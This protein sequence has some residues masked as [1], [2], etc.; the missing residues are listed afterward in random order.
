MKKDEE[1]S[2]GK[3]PPSDAEDKSEFGEGQKQQ[4][5]LLVDKNDI[6]KDWKEQEGKELNT[7]IL[8]SIVRIVFWGLIFRT[9]F[10]TRRR[11]SRRPRSS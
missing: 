3:P 5:N 2:Q 7:M 8:S 11:R 9:S 10:G 4:K 1:L 6:F